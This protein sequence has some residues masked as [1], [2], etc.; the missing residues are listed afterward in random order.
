M[1]LQMKLE[2]SEQGVVLAVAGHVT[3]QTSPALNK[4]LKSLFQDSEITTIQVKLDEV[5]QMDL[6]G[7]AILIE[8]LRWSKRTAGSFI[9]SGLTGTVRDVFELAKLDTIFEIRN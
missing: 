3:I 7:V 6:S 5:E 8:G 1:T 2:K 4:V 9:L